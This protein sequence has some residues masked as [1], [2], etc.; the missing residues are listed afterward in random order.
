MQLGLGLSLATNRLLIGLFLL[1]SRLKGQPVYIHPSASTK[2]HSKSGHKHVM[3]KTNRNIFLSSSSSP[4]SSI[5][6]MFFLAIVEGVLFVGVCVCVCWGAGSVSS[7]I[8]PAPF[9]LL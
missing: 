5:C 3:G 7:V 2:S 6:F 1:F 4:L 8:S 9:P